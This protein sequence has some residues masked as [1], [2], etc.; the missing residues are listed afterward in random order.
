MGFILLIIILINGFFAWKISSGIV[1]GILGNSPI[2]RLA[3]LIIGG[4]A[5]LWFVN[6][7]CYCEAHSNHWYS[8]YVVFGPT[9]LV[10]ITC[11]IGLVHSYMYKD[12]N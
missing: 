7:T 12:S 3:K 9:G 5:T 2:A 10:L 8:G 1:A 11:L 4:V 6:F